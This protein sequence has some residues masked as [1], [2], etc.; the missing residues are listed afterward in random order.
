[1]PTDMLALRRQDEIVKLTIQNESVT[2]AELAERFKVT[3]ATI[4]KDLRELEKKGLIRRAHGGAVTTLKPYPDPSFQ[5]RAI[6]RYPEKSAIGKFC[7]ELVRE[8]ETIMLDSGTTTLSIAEHLRGRKGITVVTNSVSAIELL[9]NE[10]D[11]TVISTGGVARKEGRSLVGYITERTLSLFR[12]DK[13]FVSV[14]AIDTEGNMSVGNLASVPAKQAMIRVAKEVIVPADSSKLGRVSIALID[15]I[16]KIGHL[17]TD[18]GADPELVDAFRKKGVKV[19][20]VPIPKA[21][22]KATS[23]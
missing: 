9:L 12:A 10:E 4:R 3:G 20:C 16:S 13:A 6:T 5:E 22:L 2:V 19:T 23:A 15:N 14:G 18:E 17:I 21:T 1:M 8:G 7:A 11:I